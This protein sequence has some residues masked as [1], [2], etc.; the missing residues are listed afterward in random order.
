MAKKTA[1]T[2]SMEDYLEAIWL[3][4]RGFFCHKASKNQYVD[5]Y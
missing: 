1:L 2:E 4:E 5:L 3:L